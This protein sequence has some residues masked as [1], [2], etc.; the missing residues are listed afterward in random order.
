MVMSDE[1]K[2]LTAYHEGGHALVALNMAASHPIHKAT[3]IPRGRALGAVFRLPEADQYSQSRAQM[4]ADL[5][6]SMGG[7]V[8]EE[9]IFGYDRVTTGASGDIKGATNMARAMVTQYG[10]SEELGPLAYGDNQEEVFLGHSVARQQNISEETA[11][12]IDSEVKRLVEEG[13]AEAKRILTE[14]IDQ[15]HTLSKGLLE[16]ETLTG[17]EIKALIKGEKPNRDVFD[18]AETPGPTSAVPSA[19]K[20][21]TGTGDLGGAPEPQPG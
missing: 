8:A 19:G 13:Y 17:D 14:H 15:L 11:R 6:V 4:E 18:D 21:Q 1:E 7:R 5:A 2:K 10:L 3:I 16:Y 9:I 20:P 12:K